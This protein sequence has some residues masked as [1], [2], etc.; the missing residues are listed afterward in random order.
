M[1]R[2]L[3]LFAALVA[4]LVVAAPVGAITNGTSDGTEH[5]YVGELLFFVPDAHDSR[6]D[7]PGG[8]FT[9]SGTLLRS[10]T[11]GRTIVVTAGHCT[12][13]VGLN[14]VTTTHDGDDTDAAHGG[15]GGNDVWI[16]FAPVPNFGILPPSSTFGRDQNP[17]R[18]QAWKNALNASSEWHRGIATPHP[19]YDDL[20]FF[21]HDAGVVKLSSVPAGV[22]GNGAVAPL[23][24][25]DRYRSQPR[26]EHRFETVGYGLER[27]QGKKEF[28]GDTRMQ[29]HPKLNSLN[30]QPPDTYMVISNNSATGG[31]CFGDSGGPTFDNTSS[32]LVVA[33]TSFGQS[34]NCGGIGGAY[35]LDQPDDLQFL[36]GFGV[37]PTS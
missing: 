13:G 25:L 11:L 27:V 5:T 20:A 29:S 24:W 2:R 37:T 4:A 23:K 7:D 28:G 34:P 14:G 18:Y 3:S 10:S 35:R 1:R 21:V 31:T 30:G 8:W 22:A 36:A 6:F 9:C 19:Q 26:N 17:Q 12:F 33:V 15:T 16:S 32:N